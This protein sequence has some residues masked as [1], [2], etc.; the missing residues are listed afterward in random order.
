MTPR[1]RDLAARY[2]D[3]VVRLL[4]RAR[5]GWGAAMPAELTG[6]SHESPSRLRA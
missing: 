5:R 3:V 2:L 1:E 4:P 6:A